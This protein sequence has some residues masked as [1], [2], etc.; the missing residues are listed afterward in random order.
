MDGGRPLCNDNGDAMMDTSVRCVPFMAAAFVQ[1]CANLLGGTSAAA[2]G[3]P[4]QLVPDWCHALEHAR[5]VILAAI[6]QY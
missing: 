5:D 6:G 2:F 3:V 4:D 1:R